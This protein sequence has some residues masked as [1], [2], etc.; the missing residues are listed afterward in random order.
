MKVTPT[1]RYGHGELLQVTQPDSPDG[2]KHSWGLV[3]VLLHHFRAGASRVG[4]P[5]TATMISESGSVY[6]MKMFRCPTCG[7]ME[8]FDDEGIDGG[9]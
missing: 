9:A 5:L 8:L 2:A 4:E 1:C 3:G 6:T 7:Y